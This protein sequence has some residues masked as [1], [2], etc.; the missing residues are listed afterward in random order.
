M[1]PEEW[2]RRQRKSITERL[3]NALVKQFRALK[4]YHQPDSVRFARVV[5]PIVKGAQHSLAEAVAESFAERSRREFRREIPAPRIPNNQIVDLRGIP[6]EEI[7]QRPFH[8]IWR[9]LQQ[10]EAEIRE[11]ERKDFLENAILKGENRL[12]AIGDEDL[13]LTYAHSAREAMNNMRGQNKPTWWRREPRGEYTCVLCWIISTRTFK[14]GELNPIHPA[15]DCAIVEE[16]GPIP[17]VVHDEELLERLHARV[18]R[19][20]GHR[21]WSG[22]GY[23]ELLLKITEEHDELGPILVRPR[24]N[25]YRR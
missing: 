22:A 15:C 16:F 24:K 11:E 12:K 6:T 21:D 9:E 17:G 25:K 3:I 4:S 5:T 2:L 8:E 18:E 20:L 10:Q 7:Y 13:Q 1:T 23:Q 14:T 19:E